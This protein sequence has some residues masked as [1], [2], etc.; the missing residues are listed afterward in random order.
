MLETP[1]YE[2]LPRV[3]KSVLL[4]ILVLLFRYRGERK[5]NNQFCLN[6]FNMHFLIVNICKG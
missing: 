3:L 2:N 6:G 4:L 5:E 1:H